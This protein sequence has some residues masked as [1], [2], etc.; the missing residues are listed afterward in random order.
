M[1]FSFHTVRESNLLSQTAQKK[2]LFFLLRF[3][4][5]AHAWGNMWNMMSNVLR[6][7][8]ANYAKLCLS[9]RHS[10]TQ[11]GDQLVR[12]WPLLEFVRPTYP[13]KQVTYVNERDWC[14]RLFLDHC[15]RF[16]L[17]LLQISC[18]KERQNNL[19]FNFCF[20]TWMITYFVRKEVKIP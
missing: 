6:K 17:F 4:N 9:L 8:Y 7:S 1:L 18:L 10:A 20:V 3:V 12:L 13:S 11:S 5:M 16:L 15:G 2:R 14:H 19:G